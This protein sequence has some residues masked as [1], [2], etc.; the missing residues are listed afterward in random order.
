[1]GQRIWESQYNSYVNIQP[2]YS[3]NQALFYSSGQHIILAGPGH[4]QGSHADPASLLSF[5]S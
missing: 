2:F 3:I 4:N 5:V 1:M